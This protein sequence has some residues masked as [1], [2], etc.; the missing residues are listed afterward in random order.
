M[1]LP[2]PLRPEHKRKNWFAGIRILP[3]P[4]EKTFDFSKLKIETMHASGPGGQNVNTGN[5]AVRITYLPDGLSVVAREERSQLRNRQLALARL[6]FRL[7]EKQTESQQDRRRELWDCHNHLER[8]N[9]VLVFRG[10]D[11]RPDVRH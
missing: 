1:G 3:E 11:F 9:P 10:P 8:G 4:D 7:Q 2:Q 6:C 5:T